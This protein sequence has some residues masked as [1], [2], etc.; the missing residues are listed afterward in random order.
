[1]PKYKII[2]E[3]VQTTMKSKVIEAESIEAAFLQAGDY[4]WELWEEDTN[5]D[6]SSYFDLRQDLS[7]EL[8]AKKKS[9]KKAAKKKK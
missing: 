3:D 5:L 1:M 9:K 6:G 8:E 7:Y 2:V 4:N